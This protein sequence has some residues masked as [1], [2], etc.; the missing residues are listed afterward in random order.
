MPHRSQYQAV[1]LNLGIKQVNLK[2]L[3]CGIPQKNLNTFLC[4][5]EPRESVRTHFLFRGKS[6]RASRL[7]FKF[8]ESPRECWNSYSPSRNIRE[9]VET[10]FLVRGMSAKVKKH[11]FSLAGVPRI[12]KLIFT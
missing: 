4:S 8:A 6:A 9:S 5:R 2:R 11:D 7:Y 3:V 1:V 10:L 12:Y